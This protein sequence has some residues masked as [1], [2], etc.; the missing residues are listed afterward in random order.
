MYLDTE[1]EMLRIKQDFCSNFIKAGHSYTL[2]SLTNTCIYIS[3]TW[4]SAFSDFRI[5]NCQSLNEHFLI[6]L[7]VS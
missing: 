1:T 3:Y 5:E 7:K 6:L 4:R 2:N